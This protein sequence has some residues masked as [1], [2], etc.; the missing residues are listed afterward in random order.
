MAKINKYQKII[1]NGDIR[2]LNK[3]INLKTLE[4]REIPETDRIRIYLEFIIENNDKNEL[5]ASSLIKEF[6]LLEKALGK[7]YAGKFIIKSEGKNRYTPIASSDHYRVIVFNG[8]KKLGI[9][10]SEETI[11]NKEQLNELK[12][13]LWH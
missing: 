7:E 12:K 13:I 11:L 5:K 9:V 2:S 1:E 8:M 10:P 4:I 6:C 3:I